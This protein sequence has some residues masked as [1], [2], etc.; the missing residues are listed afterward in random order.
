MKPR[1]KHPKIFKNKISLIM[2]L[3]KELIIAATDIKKN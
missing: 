2:K 1:I 3:I